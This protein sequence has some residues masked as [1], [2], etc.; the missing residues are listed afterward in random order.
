MEFKAIDSRRRRKRFQLRKMVEGKW[1]EVVRSCSESILRH[2][3]A[4]KINFPSLA[5]NQGFMVSFTASMTREAPENI[6]RHRGRED[7]VRDLQGQLEVR[8]RA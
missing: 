2:L 8:Q 3:L 1:K 6:Q 5:R 4:T 7:E